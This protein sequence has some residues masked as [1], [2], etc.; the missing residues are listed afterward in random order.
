MAI[1]SFEMKYCRKWTNPY[2]GG[3]DLTFGRNNHLLATE[4]DVLRVP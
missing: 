2:G 1:K 4:E 3:G